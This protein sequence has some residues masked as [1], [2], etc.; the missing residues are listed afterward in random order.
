MVYCNAS[1]C[2]G[3]RYWP[4]LHCSLEAA[5]LEVIKENLYWVWYGH[6]S[7]GKKRKRKEIL[8]KETILCQKECDS[9]KCIK[10]GCRYSVSFFGITQLKFKITTWVSQVS[11]VNNS[12]TRSVVLLKIYFVSCFCW[13]YF[14]LSLGDTCIFH[15]TFLNF[16]AEKILQ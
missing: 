10:D 4:I 14:V 1:W 5:I 16:S 9:L 2:P 6:P 8:S 12:N 13:L 7:N 3:D 11:T 15:R